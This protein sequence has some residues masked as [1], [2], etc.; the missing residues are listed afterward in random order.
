MHLMLFSQR[1]ARCAF[2]AVMQAVLATC[3][4]SLCLRP[5][6]ACWEQ[7]VKGAPKGEPT[8]VGGLF[9]RAKQAGAREGTRED[10]PGQSTQASG[11]S[12]FQGSSNT[13]AG[14]SRLM[15]SP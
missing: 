15:L 12:A 4:A 10:L 8:D 13:L 14:V 3:A 9:E 5:Q 1:L 7:V 2:S 6:H 11:S